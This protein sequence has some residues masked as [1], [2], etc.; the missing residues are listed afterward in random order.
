MGTSTL[1]AVVLP[2][3]QDAD[4]W[5]QIAT[6]V[7]NLGLGGTITI[8]VSSTAASARRVRSRYDTGER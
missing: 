8:L 6:A 2:L 4:L 1:I 3:I 5:P 7:I